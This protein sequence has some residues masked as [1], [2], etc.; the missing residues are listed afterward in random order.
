MLDTQP[1]PETILTVESFLALLQQWREKLNHISQSVADNWMNAANAV[2]E[3][4]D[5]KLDLMMVDSKRLYREYT[6]RTKHGDSTKKAV[7]SRFTNA[8]EHCIDYVKSGGT[9]E[10]HV[11]EVSRKPKLRVIEHD[12]I[13]PIES[14]TKSK[15]HQYSTQGIGYELKLILTGDGLAPGV[16]PRISTWLEGFEA[17]KQ[18]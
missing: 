6:I 13:Q 17:K 11:R 8:L 2:L 9:A 4:V 3:G 12:E 14:E 1:Q 10:Y 18:D 7:K 15:H 16:V 5:P